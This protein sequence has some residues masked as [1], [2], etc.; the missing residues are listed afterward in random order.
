MQTSPSVSS[1]QLADELMI[2]FVRLMRGDQGELFAVIAEL[3]LTMPQMRG[4]FVLNGSQQ[5]LALTELAPRMG[6]SIAAAGRAVDGLV[7]K[8][9]V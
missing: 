2:F 8:G 6:L 4:M 7:K 1:D 9:L 5:A 3:D